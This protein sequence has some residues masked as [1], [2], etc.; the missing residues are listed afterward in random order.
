MSLAHSGETGA[1]GIA[2]PAL[3][4]QQ[5]SSAHSALPELF[6]PCASQGLEANPT[7]RLLTAQPD[8][9]LPSALTLHLCRAGAELLI[10]TPC[11]A[12]LRGAFSYSSSAL[13]RANLGPWS[14]PRPCRLS[15][16][17]HHCTLLG[18]KKGPA[19][20]MQ[21]HFLR[22]G[23]G[24]PRSP[25]PTFLGEGAVPQMHLCPVRPGGSPMGCSL[26]SMIS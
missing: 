1:R 4:R 22:S 2:G 18:R 9:L 24:D 16:G 13:Y 21:W 15:P 23:P 25:M 20:L 10:S 7:G 11:R 14:G 8:T 6:L 3:S 5:S 17:H 26:W 19:V 12:A